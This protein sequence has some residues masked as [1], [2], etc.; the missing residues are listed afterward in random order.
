[1]ANVGWLLRF[2]DMSVWPGPTAFGVTSYALGASGAP[3]AITPVDGAVGVRL[4]S[5]S[6]FFIL[7]ASHASNG[8]QVEANTM[9]WVPCTPL[10][11]FF[12]RPGAA[13][14][15]QTISVMY[16]LVEKVSG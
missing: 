6:A 8:Y 10:R 14:T 2:N 15:G 5:A 7:E 13:D 3:V 12:L 4:K 16:D 9:E 1:M 11:N